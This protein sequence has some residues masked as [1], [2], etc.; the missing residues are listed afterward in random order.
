MAQEE[1]GPGHRASDV[2]SVREGVREAVQTPRGRVPACGSSQG[3]LARGLGAQLCPGH[4]AGDGMHGSVPETPLRL[5]Q[6]LR[7][8]G[9]SCGRAGVCEEGGS[10]RTRDGRV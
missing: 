2:A 10:R 5:P 1:P 6:Q 4:V 8:H 7:G 9:N 3:G